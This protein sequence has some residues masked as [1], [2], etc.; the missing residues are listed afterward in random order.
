MTFLLYG[1]NGYTGQLITEYAAQYKVN[2]IL[3]G[4]SENKLRPMAEKYGYEFLTF[5]LADT[6]ALEAAL[7]EVDVVLH[8]AGPFIHT[9]RP[10]ME[11]C[12]R[13]QTH[14]L[15]ITGEIPVFELGHRM[16]EQA[17][18][19][20]IMILPGVGFDVVPSDCLALHLR[21]QLRDATHLKLAFTNRGGGISRGTALTMVENLRQGGAVRK[22]GKIIKKPLG[23]KSKTVPFPG[24]DYF[25]MTIPWGDVA[26]AY[27]S[28]GIPNIEV[29]TGIHPS[30]YKYFRWQKY[31]NWLLRSSPVQWLAKNWVN[32][33]ISGPTRQQT[34]QAQSLLWGQVSNKQDE[35]RQARMSAPESYK[36]TALTALLITR[37]VLEGKAPSGYQTPA[38]AYGPDLIL[39]IDGVSRSDIYTDAR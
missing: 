20:G 18:S 16:D 1:A 38:R 30:R 3:A 29:Y 22:E 24:G 21:N 15:D 8:A 12:I 35:T 23:H 5:D 31:F 6:P 33:K 39:E 17:R 14:Y 37:K 7:Q 19:A 11:A 32:R 4:R 10:M 25:T 9:A 27:Y 13:T 2:P 26:T 36:L 28:T 34:Q